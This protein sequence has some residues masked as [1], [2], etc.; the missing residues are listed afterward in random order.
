MYKIFFSM[1]LLFISSL[2][3]A[4]MIIVTHQ[5]DRPAFIKMQ[6]ATFKKFLLNENH[7]PENYEYIVFNDANNPKLSSEIE[8]ACVECSIKCIEV[9]QDLHDLPYPG[10]PEGYYPKTNPSIRHA[11]AIQYSLEQLNFNQDGSL[12]I[13]DCDMVLIRPFSIVQ[14]MQ[15]FMVVS[16]I[17]RMSN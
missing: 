4:K 7:L 2:A 9:P 12:V 17:R 5:F 3:N 8:A 11:T 15:D 6:W 10:L 1:I 13:V 14:Y 16:A